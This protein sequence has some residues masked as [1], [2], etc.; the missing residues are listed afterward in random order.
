MGAYLQELANSLKNNKLRTFLTG[1]SIAWGI[2][3]LVVM[4]G[5]GK[6]VENGIRGMVTTSGVN[7]SEMT[8]YLNTTNNPYAGY[9]EGRQLEITR[10]QL[11][12]LRGMYSDRVAIMAPKIKSF[13]QVHSTFG[14]QYV[15]LNTISKEEQGFSKLELS[16]GRFFS[17]QEH[18]DGVR[19]IVLSDGH[20]T[21][22]FGYNVDPIGRLLT[23]RGVSYKVVGVVKSPSPFYATAYVPLSTFEGLYP[24]QMIKMNTVVIYPKAGQAK[25]IQHLADD[26]QLTVSQMVKS[27]PT[28]A[29]AV[30]IHKNADEAKVMDLIFNSLQILLWIMGVGSLSIGTIGVSNIMH[31]TVQ[32]R[33][34]EIG[35]RKAIGAKPRDIMRMVLGESLLLSIAAGVIG[36]LAG[37]GLVY[38]LDYL[39]QLN[40]WGQQDIPVGYMGEDVLTLTLFE[41]PE[42]NIGVAVGA[43]LV[44]VVAGA[45]A[46]YGPAKKAIKIP[47]V[48]A[49]RDMK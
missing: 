8:L 1:F 34:R 38:L 26:I 40:R 12:H 11:Q 20:L 43:L 45:I 27:D 37:I 10:Q 42:V 33:M 46:G 17:Q 22:L 47:A 30:F 9:Q 25:E 36:L 49:M 7:Q 23:L 5:A 15:Q 19:S 3:I 16:K 44:L 21:Q 35:I 6:G 48:V 39:A 29:G 24:N 14:S 2:I 32:E 13:Y 18:T 31:V 4:L 28:D 41:N